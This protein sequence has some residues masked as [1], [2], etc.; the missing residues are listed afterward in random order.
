LGAEEDNQF[1]KVIKRIVHPKKAF[2]VLNGVLLMSRED[3]LKMLEPDNVWKVYQK[4]YGLNRIEI[5]DDE[6][7]LNVRIITGLSRKAEHD[8]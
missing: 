8:K 4:G 2:K 1:K 5:Y 7:E 3:F 6:T